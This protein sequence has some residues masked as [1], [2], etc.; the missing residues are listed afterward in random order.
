MTNVVLTYTGNVCSTPMIEY[1]RLSDQI[2]VPVRE[3]FDEYLFEK[4]YP[5]KDTM[6]E[7][8][9]GI[10]DAL[11]CRQPVPDLMTSDMVTY[12]GRD[13]L[14]SSDVTPHILFKWRCF[15]T[16]LPGSH[17]ITDVFAKHDVQPVVILRQSIIEQAIKVFLSEKTYGGRHQ[18]FIAAK[19]SQ[20]EY[21]AYLKEQE[22]IS[23]TITRQDIGA[24]GDILDNFL[25]RTKKLVQRTQTFFPH[26]KPLRCIIAEDLFKPLI[27][28]DAY[29]DTL[30]R[31]FGQTDPVF[32]DQSPAVRKGG[33]NLSNCSNPEF[34]FSHPVLSARE[35][36][37]HALIRQLDRISPNSSSDKAKIGVTG[38]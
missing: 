15:D 26:A 2:F 10:L 9:A 8:L 25:R 7:Q 5:D 19:M 3:E 35:D 22:D 28:L 16:D 13:E 29:N 6:C 20:E 32:P 27:D 18:Q 24:I 33:L 36:E 17:K 34:A 38:Q 37:Y 12:R 31:M 14:P 1:A 11:Y 21:E 30:T 4:R 23:V